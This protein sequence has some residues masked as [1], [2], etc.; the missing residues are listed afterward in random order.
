MC[1]YEGSNLLTSENIVSLKEILFFFF[2]KLKPC[3][4]IF[5]AVSGGFQ[6]GLYRKWL[7][8]V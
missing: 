3:T 2:F 1:S 8:N 4:L 6:L 7:E 5:I